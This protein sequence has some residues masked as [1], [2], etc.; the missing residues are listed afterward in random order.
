MKQIKINNKTY[1]YLY[2]FDGGAYYTPDNAGS[3]EAW[4]AVMDDGTL[5]LLV[6]GEHIPYNA[7]YEII[8]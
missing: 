1:T 8:K 5:Q 7:E 3:C 2:S 4:V 6:N